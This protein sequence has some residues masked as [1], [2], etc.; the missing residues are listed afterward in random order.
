MSR[1]SRRLHR[2][3]CLKQLASPESSTVGSDDGGSVPSG[4]VFATSSNVAAV[5]DD[6][7]PSLF[8][9]ADPMARN[10]LRRIRPRDHVGRA[11][12][13]ADPGP[14]GFST[15]RCHHGLEIA[16]DPVDGLGVGLPHGDGGVDDLGFGQHQ[17]SALASRR[18]PRCAG[19]IV[20]P[21][22]RTR[23]TFH[24][25]ILILIGRPSSAARMTR[26]C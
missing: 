7:P 10:Q 23:S 9:C 2:L 13:R 20:Q 26:S 4:S 22:G 1:R 19:A 11:P 18:R 24:V 5:V 8:V 17:M 25:A 12:D 15:S 21:L 6:W 14:D 3:A 16:I